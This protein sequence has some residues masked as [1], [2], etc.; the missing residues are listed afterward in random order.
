MKLSKDGIT[1]AS[2]RIKQIENI[3]RP[4]S[5]KE[6]KSFLGMIN[7]YRAWLPK[8]VEIVEPLQNLLRKDKNFFW[9][10]DLEMN[11]QKIKNWLA[12]VITMNYFDSEAPI[13]LSCDASEIGL[14]ATL[15]NE[16]KGS[17]KPLTYWSRRLNEREVRFS[18]AEK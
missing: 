1:P 3:D 6:I 15:Q 14:G 18:I 16:I 2:D 12:K 11:F 9:N 13:V 4:H 8:Y 7:Y 10:H 17:L 5:L